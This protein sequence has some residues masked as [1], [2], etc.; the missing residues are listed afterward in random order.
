[1]PAW[2]FLSVQVFWVVQFRSPARQP[3]CWKVVESVGYHRLWCC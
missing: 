3:S 1:M 2:P